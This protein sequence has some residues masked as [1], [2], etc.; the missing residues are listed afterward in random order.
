MSLM[1]MG[2]GDGMGYGDGGC[3]GDG[4]GTVYYCDGKEMVMGNEDG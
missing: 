4:D 3:N 2:D 1:A